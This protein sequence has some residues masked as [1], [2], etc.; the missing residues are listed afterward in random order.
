MIRSFFS[1]SSGLRHSFSLRCVKDCRCCIPGI[2]DD[3]AELTMDGKSTKMSA[4]CSIS[5]FILQFRP[6][7]DRVY[8]AHSQ[9]CVHDIQ[10]RRKV[11]AMVYQL[12][13]SCNMKYMG[14]GKGGD[15]TGTRDAKHY[16]MPPPVMVASWS[17]FCWFQVAIFS[18]VLSWY[19]RRCSSVSAFQ[20]SE[21]LPS[22]SA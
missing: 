11:A 2:L 7:S 5:I 21:T 8:R 15:S 16:S 1:P 22:T 6:P 9:I 17:F 13:R 4:F 14:T 3:M 12:R 18:V 19:T 20:A 10:K